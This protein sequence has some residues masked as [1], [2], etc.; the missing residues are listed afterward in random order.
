MAYKLPTISP[1]SN[2]IF[3][4]TATNNDYNVLTTDELI[5]YTGTVGPHVIVLPDV[6]TVPVGKAYI[7]VDEGGN[8]ASSTIEVE[9]FNPGGTQ[10]INN[11][12]IFVFTTN[13]QV[14]R[15]YSAGTTW[16]TW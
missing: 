9:V 5:A 15:I 13:Y 14:L 6:A 10:K 8:A 3:N 12:Y 1:L 7:I 4:R 16:F 11:V 2:I